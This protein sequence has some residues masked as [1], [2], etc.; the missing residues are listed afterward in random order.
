MMNRFG[1]TYHF[2][3]R[4]IHWSEKNPVEKSIKLRMMYDRLAADNVC[5]KYLNELLDLANEVGYNEAEE[6]AAENC[7]EI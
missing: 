5:E 4:F 6:D 3:D 1:M 7:E 2:T